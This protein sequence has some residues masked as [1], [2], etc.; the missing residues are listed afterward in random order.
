MIPAMTIRA[1]ENAASKLLLKSCP[2]PADHVSGADVLHGRVN[3]VGVESRGICRKPA[4]NASSTEML[5]NPFPVFALE[6]LRDIVVTILAPRAP[7]T[8]RIGL[9]RLSVTFLELR[10]VCAA[11]PAAAWVF[12]GR[13]FAPIALESRSFQGDKHRNLTAPKFYSGLVER[14]ALFNMVQKLFYGNIK[15]IVNY[16]P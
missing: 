11:T 15:H 6:F 8:V 7:R 14:S 16:T 9:V 3:V 4:K 5:D 1:Q 10:R 13:K 12:L 2:L